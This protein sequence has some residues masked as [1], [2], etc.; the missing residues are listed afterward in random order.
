MMPAWGQTIDFFGKIWAEDVGSF[1]GILKNVDGTS[2]MA[3]CVN[4]PLSANT[5]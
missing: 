5:H 2:A 4:P 1:V 3:L